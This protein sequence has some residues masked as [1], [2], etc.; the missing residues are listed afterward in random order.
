MKRQET[1]F[2]LLCKTFGAVLVACGTLIRVVFPLQ[3]CV[4]RATFPYGVHFNSTY[5]TDMQPVGDTAVHRISRPWV[6]VHK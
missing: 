3:I 5:N 1:Q 2:L 4:I 6:I